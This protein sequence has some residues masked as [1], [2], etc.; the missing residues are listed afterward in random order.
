MDNEK[1][2][3]DMEVEKEK[4]EELPISEEQAKINAIE[5][6][7]QEVEILIDQ[8]D[9][10]IAS[11]NNR[12]KYL[13]QYYDLKNRYKDL[14]KQKKAIRITR[15]HSK[16]DQLHTWVPIYGFIIGIL[17]LPFFGMFIWATF[18]KWL[19]SLFPKFMLLESTSYGLFVTLL[20]LIYYSLP[21]ILLFISWLLYVN[22]VKDGF[23]RKVFK[24]IWIG[25]GLFTIIN[26]LFL[27]FKYILPT[28]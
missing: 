11:E 13:E 1:L 14:L 9:A 6:E 15:T 20:L 28:L 4:Q 7:L 2:N 5:L 10:K 12:E 17:C 24:Y 26:A 16:W 18:S 19:I 23:E 21:I 25:Q 27:L 3:N 8:L 22:V